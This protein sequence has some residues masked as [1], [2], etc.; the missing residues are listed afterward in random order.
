MKKRIVTLALA[1]VLCVGSAIPAYAAGQTFSD[2]PATYW[3]YDEIERAYEDG[4]MGGTSYDPATGVRVFSPEQTLTLAQYI[5]VL[6]RA[7]YGDEVEAFEDGYADTATVW[8]AHNLTVANLHQLFAGMGGQMQ[9]HMTE[10]A[11]RYW[12]AAIMANLMRDQGYDMPTS[13]ELT[14]VQAR[15]GDWATIP[16]QYQDAVATVFSLGL[17]G[18]VDDNGTFAGTGTVKRSTMAVIYT[19]MADALDGSGTTTTPAPDPTTETDE[20]EE[21]VETPDEDTST[22]AYTLANGKPITEDNVMALLDELKEKYPNG[23]TYDPDAGYYSKAFRVTGYDCALMALK[24]SDEIWGDLPVRSHTDLSNIRVGDVLQDPNHW[25][26]VIAPPVPNP[27][28]QGVYVKTVDGGP[29]GIL[30]WMG[31]EG[32]QVVK[33]GKG[34]VVWTRYPD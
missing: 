11:T 31:D 12:M 34:Y 27:S 26:V 14:A 17:I 25:A 6:T 21:P 2:V 22:N 8:Y 3:A 1:L 15:I 13:A 24:I 33:D 9:T 7:F 19:R 23:Y 20:P 29:S 18:G 16:E 5:V 4:V 30:T 10:P 28:G 32:N